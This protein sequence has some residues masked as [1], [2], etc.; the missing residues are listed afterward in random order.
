MPKRIVLKR[1]IPYL[2]AVQPVQSPRKK[3]VRFHETALE[4]VVYFHK[5]MPA[6][7]IN[8]ENTLSAH[9]YTLHQPNWPSKTRILY[10]E[11][12]A[13]VRMESVQLADGES[14]DGFLLEGKCR[15]L[16]I[17]YQKQISVRYTFD[18]W[19]TFKE[20]LG[21]FKE[22]IGSTANTWD[23][24]DFQIPVPHSDRPQTLYLAL[25]YTV[26]GQDYWDNNHGANYHL[27]LQPPQQQQQPKP[28]SKPS[29]NK[30]YDFSTSAA[31]YDLPPSPPL[32]PLPIQP[33]YTNHTSSPHDMTYT[34]FV[35]KYCFYNPSNLLYSTS[36]SA[37]FT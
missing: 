30:R 18:L 29:L 32:S 15:A 33:S 9:D 20:T 5:S 35:N 7:T 26:N 3:A 14:K 37:V 1:A 25:K 22:P 17:S 27:L 11:Q 6:N 8:D 16:N 10:Q 34:D 31:T 23:R 2:P 36:P 19:S 24:F 12:E 4:Q 21:V 28:P 13:K